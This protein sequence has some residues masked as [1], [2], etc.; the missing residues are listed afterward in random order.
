MITLPVSGTAQGQTPFSA[1]SVSQ[2]QNLQP[3]VSQARTASNKSGGDTVAHQLS[4]AG[5]D[6]GAGVAPGTSDSASHAQSY[7]E[8]T[9]LYHFREMQRKQ[10]EFIKKRVLL[11][12]KA[13]TA[14]YQKEY[15]VSS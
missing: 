2:A 6:N 5:N 12:E 10:V 8:S 1:P 15:F 7:Q 11:L 3:G 14:E 4:G 9:I 13:L